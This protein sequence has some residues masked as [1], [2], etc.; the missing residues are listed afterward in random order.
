M[1]TAERYAPLKRL[2][3]RKQLTRF[4]AVAAAA[5]GETI[6]LEPRAFDV[7]EVA[8]PE[9]GPLGGF[10]VAKCVAATYDDLPEFC[11]RQ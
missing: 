4:A 5:G 9:L 6:V 11:S 2:R 3:R 7:F 10:G 8:F 1:A